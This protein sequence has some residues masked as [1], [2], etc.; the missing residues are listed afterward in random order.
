MARFRATVVILAALLVV[1]AASPP[2]KADE[3][4]AKP[5][6]AAKAQPNI[7]EPRLDLTIWS[8][9]VFA[10]LL[11]FLGRFAWKPMLQGLKKREGDIH[12]A[13]EDARAAREEGQR[14]RDEV[15]A[16]REK[17]EAMRRDIIQRAQA[18]A[19]RLADEIK[20]SNEAAMRTE[21]EQALREL[22]SAKDQALQ[23]LWRHTADL[24]AMVSTKAIRRNLTPE[25][26]RRFVDEAL[27]DLRKEAGNGHKTTASA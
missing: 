7:F 10:V 12:Q 13:I 6:A 4:P 3:P 16:E 15:R 2:A 25:D 23:E 24:A 8:I 17:T 1:T 26:H 22:Q 14:L 9:I 5:E 20:A 18:D 27:A 11:W 19:Q 21:R